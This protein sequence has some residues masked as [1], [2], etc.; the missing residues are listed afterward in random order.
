MY[1][2]E[3]FTSVVIASFLDLS[4]KQRSE[5]SLLNSR[6]KIFI[7]INLSAYFRS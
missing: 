7:L 6:G 2:M 1:F 4:S 3:L 5:K